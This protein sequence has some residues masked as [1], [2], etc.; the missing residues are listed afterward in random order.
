MYTHHSLAVCMNAS[1]MPVYVYLRVS[2]LRYDD[3]GRVDGYPDRAPPYPQHRFH[4]LI[5]FVKRSSRFM[6]HFMPEIV[7]LIDFSLEYLIRNPD[8]HILI[9]EGAAGIFR[10][11]LDPFGI[12]PARLVVGDESLSYYADVLYHP[13]F[14]PKVNFQQVQEIGFCQCDLST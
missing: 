1:G 7:P 4:R 5:S 14:G 10:Y 9:P 6:Q 13:S 11:L 12:D 3:M 2:I 8:M